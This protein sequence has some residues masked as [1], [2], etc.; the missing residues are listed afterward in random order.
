MQI[1]SRWRPVKSDFGRCTR[2]S[3]WTVTNSRWKLNWLV[4]RSFIGYFGPFIV[5]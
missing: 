2:I 1:N 3:R 4:P 5:Q